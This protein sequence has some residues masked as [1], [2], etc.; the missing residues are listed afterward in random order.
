MQVELD[1]P[2]PSE[3]LPLLVVPHV[4]HATALLAAEKL[5][6]AQGSC[7]TAPVVVTRVPSQSTGKLLAVTG[8]QVAAPTDA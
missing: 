8:V 4:P 7:P 6:A 3:Y 5:P 2:R 1:K